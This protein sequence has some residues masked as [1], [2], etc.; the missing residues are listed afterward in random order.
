MNN[1]RD[2]ASL[3][4]FMFKT[5]SLSIIFA[6]LSYSLSAQAFD[7]NKLIQE[8]LADLNVISLPKDY[9]AVRYYENGSLFREEKGSPCL[10]QGITLDLNQSL[11]LEQEET[12]FKEPLELFRHSFLEDDKNKVDPIIMKHVLSQFVG[13][14]SYNLSHV[15]QRTRFTFISY[16]LISSDYNHLS[17]EELKKLTERTFRDSVKYSAQS[18]KALENVTERKG[19]NITIPVYHDETSRENGM[20]FLKM[21]DGAGKNKSKVLQTY[22]DKGFPT[23]SDEDR[24]KYGDIIDNNTAIA[25]HFFGNSLTRPINLT[26]RCNSKNDYCRWA[27]TTELYDGYRDFYPSAGGFYK[28]FEE[29]K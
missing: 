10:I 20:L 14:N 28:D 13:I 24:K 22:L 4:F 26:T 12:C 2:E 23:L 6:F 25:R 11:F 27:I 9:R 8:K 15:L 18:Y 5:L 29:E 19:N 7:L 16:N 21:L 1:K 3:F 17:K